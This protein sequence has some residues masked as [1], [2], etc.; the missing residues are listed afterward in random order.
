M[1]RRATL[2]PVLT[3][4]LALG[5]TT[6]QVQPPIEEGSTRFAVLGDTGT[7]DDPQYEV[8]ERLVESREIFPFDFAI[9]LGDN[10]YGSEDAD[11]YREKF[12]VPYGPLL[13]A[14]VEFYASLGNHDELNQ[15]FYEP[16]NMSGERY[17][18]FRKGPIRFFAL[19]SNYMDPEQLAWFESELRRSNDRWK[20]AFF[21]HPLYSPG[22]KHGSE[23]DLRELVEPLMLQ[24]GLD[25][26]F[27]GHEH[28][29]AR[30]KPQHGIFHFVAGASAK[31]RRGDIRPSE[32]T[33]TGNDQDRSFM[34]IEVFDDNL[35]FQT[36]LRTGARVDAGVLPRPAEPE[37][38]LT[39][40]DP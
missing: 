10:M 40:G 39:A 32:L 5:A 19:D 30:L 6:L 35:R 2:V 20:I 26:V 7:G 14:G 12:E 17:Y 3:A 13:D 16:F 37:R 11:D 28:F 9:M 15:R 25:V 36:I 1:K 8:A 23:E 27:A 4:L 18:T 22:T 31:L 21:H 34:L 33:V 38:E 24:Y 29:Y